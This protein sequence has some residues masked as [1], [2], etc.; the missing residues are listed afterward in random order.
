MVSV[1]YRKSAKST[2]Q[3]LVVFKNEETPDRINNL[4]ARKPM[5]DNRYIIDAMGVGERFIEYYKNKYNIKN[6]KVE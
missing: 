5:L 4:R 1:V 3:Y 6:H 2:K